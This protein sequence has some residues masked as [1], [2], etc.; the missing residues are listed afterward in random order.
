[1]LTFSA[2]GLGVVA[3]G[4]GGSSRPNANADAVDEALTWITRVPSWNS[5]V[6]R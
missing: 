1:M 4:V 3:F 2:I 6:I 5:K